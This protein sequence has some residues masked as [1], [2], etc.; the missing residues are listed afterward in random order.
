MAVPPVRA[1]EL[2]RF[3]S[4]FN[5]T[6]VG[7]A[8]ITFVLGP[9]FPNIGLG[10]VVLFGVLLVGQ[11]LFVT[12]LLRSGRFR[13][14]PEPVARLIFSIDLLLIAYAIIL[15]SY[16]P[17]WTTYIVGLLVVIAGGFRFATL[18]ALTAAFAMAAT[19]VFAALYREESFGYATEPQRVVFT[20]AIYLLA[21]FLMTGLLRELATLRAQREAF[22]HQRA[23]TEAL[24]QLDKMKSE[25]LAEMSHD[26][27]SP[28]TVVRGTLELLLSERPGALRPEQR[29]LAQRA[30][31]NVRRLEEFSEDLLEMAR[32]EHGAVAL[33]RVEI[34][35]CALVREVV[36]DHRPLSDGRQQMLHVRCSTQSV[37][38]LADIGRLR[39][40]ISNLI[41]NAIKYGP[42]GSAIAIDA[43]RDDGAFVVR[44][45]DSGPGVEPDERERIF[46]KFSR[47]R[48][49][50]SLA[51]AG[52]GLSI[53]RSLVELHG[54]SLRYEDAAGGGATF[55][56]SVPVGI[57]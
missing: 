33:E 44:V 8:A 49:T 13:R 26:F 28:I 25:F 6:R 29:S 39:R 20:V 19:Y 11:A 34:D 31:R 56:L 7:G 43:S 38:I 55:V 42:T 57:E 54:G 24:R 41:V 5:R 3:E 17:N 40:A 50:A 2:E 46:E 9:F 48:R 32:I 51:G 23:E 22:E 15:F 1:V 12:Y 35:G 53:A 18:G 37:T 21:G 52:L 16:D 14:S 47:G 4:T 10:H 36:E 27:R 30:D 45:S